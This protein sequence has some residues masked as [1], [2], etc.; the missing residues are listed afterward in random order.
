MHVHVACSVHVCDL[1]AYVALPCVPNYRF[2]PVHTLLPVTH[3]SPSQEIY[4]ILS[5]V[6]QRN[7]ARESLHAHSHLFEAWRQLV[8]MVLHAV[9]TQDGVTAEVRMTV[10]FEME[11][12]LLLK[13]QGPWAGGWVEGIRVWGP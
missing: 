5:V 1:H 7:R 4:K 6:F 8:E 3:L 10:L 13:V 9:P 12:D 11:Q 2:N